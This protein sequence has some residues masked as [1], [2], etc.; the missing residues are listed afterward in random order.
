MLYQLSQTGTTLSGVLQAK[1][2]GEKKGRVVLY[3]QGMKDIHCYHTSTVLK[4][5]KQ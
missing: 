4:E 1:K 3:I 5:Y 2:K